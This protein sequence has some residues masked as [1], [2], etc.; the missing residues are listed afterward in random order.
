MNRVVSP[1]VVL[2]VIDPNAAVLAQN[3]NRQPVKIENPQALPPS[4][5]EPEV[6]DNPDPES[7]SDSTNDNPDNPNETQAS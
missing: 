4:S 6:P 7:N 2:R 1:G 3:S 5:D